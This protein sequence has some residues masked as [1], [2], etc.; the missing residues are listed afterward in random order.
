[1]Q[2]LFKKGAI[3]APFC[4]CPF[5]K[6]II[7]FKTFILFVGQYAYLCIVAM[8]T[9]IYLYVDLFPQKIFFGEK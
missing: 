7:S 6:S 3:G 2:N 4:L 1:M 5:L 8:L 9:M